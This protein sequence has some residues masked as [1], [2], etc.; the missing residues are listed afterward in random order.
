MSLN[1]IHYHCGPFNGIKG[2]SRNEADEACRM[3]D[4]RYGELQEHYGSV[5]WPYRNWNYAD[6]L[7]LED[8]RKIRRKLLR[9]G[10]KTEALAV[11]AYIT[12][13][14]IKKKMFQKMPELEVRREV[15]SE[16]KVH[17]DKFGRKRSAASAF[18]DARI[19]RLGPDGRSYDELR[20]NRGH[21]EEQ[22]EKRDNKYAMVVYGDQRPFEV[23][24]EKMSYGAYKSGA[25]RYVR[26]KK[27]KRSVGLRKPTSRR[28]KPKTRMPSRSQLLNLLAVPHSMSFAFSQL[29]EPSAETGKAKW[30]SSPVLYDRWMMDST[31]DGQ[32]SASAGPFTANANG[33]KV[34]MMNAKQVHSVRNQSDYRVFVQAYLVKPKFD[35]RSNGTY[36]NRH[37]A[38]DLIMA[39]LHSYFT[40][41]LA[42]GDVTELTLTAGDATNNRHFSHIDAPSFLDITKDGDVKEVFNI[43]KFGGL[44]A[45]ESGAS[46]KYTIQDKKVRQ[47][48]SAIHSASTDDGSVPQIFADRSQMLMFK[49]WGDVVG[50]SEVAG[51]N[52]D[53]EKVNTSTF[54]VVH[55][56]VQEVVEKHISPIREQRDF[57]DLRAG[58]NPEDQMAIVDQGYAPEPPEN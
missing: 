9:A 54:K 47:M 10:K 36:N 4:I 22:E 16:N 48:L 32:G 19:R 20:S 35:L 34:Y 13:F 37:A 33:D 50:T 41:D 31:A 58:I 43:K 44:R 26:G 29:T 39:R 5:T 18:A 30:Q 38:P 23:H 6:V 21:Y 53:D 25:G 28:V 17:Q 7:F 52:E 55:E 12:T 1:P 57:V 8:L 14:K 24:S 40:N 11:R 56:I 51:D 49:Y 42:A 2:E 27:R 15:E 45:L 3:H 46:T